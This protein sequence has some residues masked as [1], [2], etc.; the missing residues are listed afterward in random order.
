MET[1]KPLIGM[2]VHNGFNAFKASIESLIHST[3]CPFKLLIVESESTDGSHEY[4]KI[5]PQLYPGIEIE[6][7][8]TKKEGPLKAYNMLFQKAKEYQMDLYLIQTDVIHFRLYGRDWLYEMTEVA[9]SE[10]VGLIAPLGAWGIAHEWHN[11]EFQWAGGWAC[12]IPIRTINLI[13]GYDEGYEI[14]DG[15]D[16]DYTYN[17]QKHGLKCIR[18]PFWVQHHWMTEH[19]HEKNP[20]LQNIRKRNREY[21]RRKY[22]IKEE[23]SPDMNF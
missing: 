9:K 20:D 11:Q 1:K 23:F 16:I 5:L 12:Y 4:A 17:V 19:E 14:G 8:H 7:I 2:P 15:V 6:I 10:D 13:G 18:A 3:S 22:D 21:F